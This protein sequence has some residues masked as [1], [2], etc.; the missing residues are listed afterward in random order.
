MSLL[1][2]SDVAHQLGISA[3]QVY[4]LAAS[5][6]LPAYRFGRSLRFE[7][8]D[9]AEYKTSCRSR[10]IRRAVSSS[11]SLTV[12]SAAHGSALES[13]FQKLGIKPRLTSSTARKERGSTPRQ[14]ASVVKLAS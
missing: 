2:A 12:G 7:P 3:R 5:G 6:T 4:D 1:S 13:A 14:T 11:L 9:I 10:G 8:S